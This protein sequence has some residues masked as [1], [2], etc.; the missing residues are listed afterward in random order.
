MR[1]VEIIA[2]KRD[3][4]PLSRDEIKF[5]VEG[6]TS[7][8]IPDY[9]TA[10]W[11]MAVVLRG[12]DDEETVALTRALAESGE[13]LDLSE[14]APVVLDKHSTGGVGDK[15]TL[16]VAPLVAAAGLPVGKMSGR[17][18]GFTGG[19]LDKLEAFPGFQVDLGLERFVRT[20]KE[21]GIVVAGQTEDLAPG[22]AVLYALRD[23]TATVR[24]I[25]LIASSV[26]SKKIAAGG[27]AIVLDVK[28]GRGAFMQT[29]EEGLELA[30]V[31]IRIGSG[32]GRRVAAVIADMSQ[33]LGR[34]VGNI[35]EVREAISTLQGEGPADFTQHTLIVASQM[36]VLGQAAKD[37]E[38]ARAIVER[39]LREGSGL[40]KL[41][42][43]VSGQGGDASFVGDPG[44]FP[45]APVVRE[46]GAPRDGFLA[47]LDAREVGLAAVALGAGRAQ[48]GDPIDHRVGLVLHRKVGERV[49]AGDPLFSIHS[50][51][52]DDSERAE[53]R[54]L[55]ACR[56]SDNE[57]P[58]PT[59]IHQVLP[60]QDS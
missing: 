51:T 13:I 28:I 8:E 29:L 35:L 1:P 23:V 49:S 9:Q 5:L 38:G 18:L 52:V 2:K 33:P 10:A 16:T 17:G 39:C 37:E 55:Q 14:V 58:T 3:G 59:L 31:M 43:L 45:S 41:E 12:M 26:M 19:T 24:S 36:L 44:K 54:L 57:V 42:D 56:W 22:D 25:P 34:T 15:T 40:A 50:R 20:L 53:A 48:K 6:A 27:H 30:Q 32:L 21:T 60:W 11:L 46:I 4:L 7:S 47:A